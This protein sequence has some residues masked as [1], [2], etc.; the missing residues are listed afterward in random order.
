MEWKP[1]DTAPFERDLEVAV[2]DSGGTRFVAFPCRVSL[3]TAGS[4]SKPTSEFTT[5]APQ[6]AGSC[7]LAIVGLRGGLVAR[8]TQAPQTV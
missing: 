5:Y 2:I 7:L 4:M 6:A 1:I 8:Q 3:T